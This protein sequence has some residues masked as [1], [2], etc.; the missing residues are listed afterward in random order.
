MFLRLLWDIVIFRL[1]VYLLN[2]ISLNLLILYKMVI[3]RF[4]ERGTSDRTLE[5]LVQLLKCL[6]FSL[7]PLYFFFTVPLRIIKDEKNFN[8][9]CYYLIVT[10]FLKKNSISQFSRCVV[11]IF[12]YGHTFNFKSLLWCIIFIV[13]N[14]F[15]N[16][17]F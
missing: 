16:K 15:K 5:G 10:V 12:G 17:P 14:V 7:Y 4:L 3:Y 9:N 6:V 8:I 13:H 11:P 1:V 2:M